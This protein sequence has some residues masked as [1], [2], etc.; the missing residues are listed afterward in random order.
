MS[1]LARLFGG[2]NNKPSQAAA[3]P[4]KKPVLAELSSEALFEVIR[5]QSQNINTKLEAIQQLPAGKELIQVVASDIDNK[6]QAAGAKRLATLLDEETLSLASLQA[7]LSD[8]QCLIVAGYAKNTAFISQLI[9]SNLSETQL[10]ELAVN[11]SSSKIRQAAATKLA[12][13]DILQSVSKSIKS[14]DK[15]VY[16]IVKDKLEL[17]KAEQREQQA[18]HQQLEQLCENV[19]SLAKTID[20]ATLP[21]RA[22]RFENE[23]QT[24]TAEMTENPFISAYETNIKICKERVE[25]LRQEEEK[26]LEKVR[27][28]AAAK[29]AFKFVIDGLRDFLSG[30]YDA[31]DIDIDFAAKSTEVV[32]TKQNDWHQA[33]NAARP[34][35]EQSDLFNK[36]IEAVGS[37]IIG[38][39][40]KGSLTQLTDKLKDCEDE[41]VIE[42]TQKQ[43]SDLLRPAKLLTPAQ[44]PEIVD[45]T[46]AAISEFQQ[47]IEKQH[48]EE[49]SAIRQLVGLI[50]KVNSFIESGNLRQASGLRKAINEKL[51]VIEQ[52][53]SRIETQIEELDE[54]IN[55]LQDYRNFATEPKKRELITEMQALADIAKSYTDKNLDSLDRENLADKVKKLQSDWKELVYG[56]KDTQPELWDEFHAL[57]QIAFEP[58]KEFFNEK[59][60]ERQQ[61]LEKRKD[62]LSQ[63]ELYLD[64]NDWEHADW[65]EVEKVLRTA[66]QEWSSYTPVERAANAPVQKSFN[67]ALKSIQSFVDKEYEKNKS[68]KASVVAQAKQLESMENTQDAIAKVKQLQAQWKNCGRTWQKDENKLWKEFRGYCDAVFDRK[69]KESDAFKS[70]LDSNKSAALAECEKI[71]SFGKLTGK[72]LIDSRDSVE[73][74]KA[75]FS[76]ITPLP[77][78][79]EKSI[80]SRFSRAVEAFEQ[81]VEK[82]R[83][84]EQ[85]HAWEK[86][87]ECKVL[88]NQWQMA[89]S[90]GDAEQEKASLDEAIENIEKWP[91][92]TKGVI[93]KLASTSADPDTTEENSQAM[94]LLCIQLETVMD[95][96]SPEEDKALRMEYQVNRL[97]EG[98]ISSGSLSKHEQVEKIVMTWL[99]CGPV[100]HNEFERFNAR[101]NS[102]RN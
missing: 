70:E 77:K 51:E 87:L 76:D 55:K 3:A 49:Q 88:L 67:S 53:P 22:S 71:E 28:E 10:A 84:N 68:S 40:Q 75:A 19:A 20:T 60:E 79:A 50:R 81:A 8:E 43:I 56:G 37:L 85:S 17:Y 12:S 31:Q 89:S 24:L 101:F 6:V 58:C 41:A 82:Q 5:S 30:L 78:N 16:K 46:R 102:A 29:D 64:K 33:L 25:Q 65:K 74:A 63:L 73:E 97:K 23:W 48:E 47:K 94:R 69:Q 38:L 14:K 27:A 9:E 62:I 7:E 42:E 83:A 100:E 21:Q 57:S 72:A 36:L 99:E 34:T 4:V 18:L 15:T 66:K 35:K 39:S 32:E 92:K 11:G 90:T 95:I 80:R 44:V 13:L 96:P 59:A 91:G 45:K 54:G 2:K 61:N 26:R 52:L 93:T 1:F 86:V 98:M